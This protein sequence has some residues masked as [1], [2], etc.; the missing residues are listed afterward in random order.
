MTQPGPF[1]QYGRPRRISGGIKARATRGPI[2]RS[3]WSRRFLQVLES[4]AIGGRLGRGRAYARAGQVM[5]LEVRPGEVAAVV[6]GSRPEPYRVAVRLAA[7]PDRVWRR[8]EAALTAQA[9]YAARLLAGE[10]PPDIEDV[11]A[12]AGAPLFPRRL[13]DLTM[14]CSCPDFAVPC[15]HLAATFYLLAEAF[16]TDPFQILHWRGRDRG[17]LL[18][19][20]RALRGAATGPPPTGATGPPPTGAAGIPASGA[21]PGDA[22][23]GRAHAA[24]TTPAAGA[25]AALSEVPS[26]PLRDTLDRYWVAPVPLPARPSTLDTDADLLLRQL[27][28][29]PVALGGAALRE[30]LRPA[31]R[32]FAQTDSATD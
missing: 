6:Q 27:P 22:A 16:D 26:P 3:W 14:E 7:F 15:K 19:R 20:L 25:A 24:P 21:T 9:I 13:A 23:G 8:V 5:S 28:E 10:M 30:R 29:P 32:R 2:G 17:R 31:Y 11:F 4:F 18:G 1:A 12:A